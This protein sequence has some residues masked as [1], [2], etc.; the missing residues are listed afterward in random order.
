MSLLCIPSEICADLFYRFDFC[1]CSFVVKT[2]FVHIISFSSIRHFFFRIKQ[3]PHQIRHFSIG[4]EL[5]FVILWTPITTTKRSLKSN[6]II[7]QINLNWKKKTKQNEFVIEIIS[8]NG[9]LCD[10]VISWFYSQK[11]TSFF[12]HD[13]KWKCWV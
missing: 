12:D 11:C 3:Q 8:F 13:I 9:I 4:Y 5:C 10:I 7:K 2:I 1:L 6:G